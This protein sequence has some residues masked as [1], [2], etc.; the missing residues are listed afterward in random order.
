MLGIGQGTERPAA[1]VIRA[2]SVGACGACDKV[3]AG[4]PEIVG[5]ADITDFLLADGGGALDHDPYQLTHKSPAAI[6]H[7][8]KTPRIMQLTGR[9]CFVLRFQADAETYLSQSLPFL[10]SNFA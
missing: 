8:G 9:T 1:Q 2:T 4:D 6:V 3:E 10:S 5:G 7:R